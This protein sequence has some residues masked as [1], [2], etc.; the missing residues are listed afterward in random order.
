MKAV[1]LA[2]MKMPRHTFT[3]KTICLPRWRHQ[4][5]LLGSFEVSWQ[6]SV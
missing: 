2:M 4:K 5:H 1:Q 3:R 6:Q